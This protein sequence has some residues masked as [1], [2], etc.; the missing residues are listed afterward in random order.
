MTN[1]DELRRLNQ[2]LIDLKNAPMLSKA[3]YAETAVR[4]ALAAL[5]SLYTRLK[6]I[7][8]A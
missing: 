1:H 2:A 3:P 5:D 7:E 8:D 6:R 4:E